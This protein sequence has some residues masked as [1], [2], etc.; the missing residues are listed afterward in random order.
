MLI[1]GGMCHKG[2]Q[3]QIGLRLPDYGTETPSKTVWFWDMKI[4]AVISL[5][6]PKYGL[7]GLEK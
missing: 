6:L 3:A 5:C 1:I 7:I 4:S 2:K